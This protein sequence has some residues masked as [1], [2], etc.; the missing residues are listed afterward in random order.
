MTDSFQQVGVHVPEFPQPTPLAELLFSERDETR[1]LDSFTSTGSKIRARFF[2]GES[3]EASAVAAEYHCSIGNFSATVSILRK[4][5]YE[6]DSVRRDDGNY[7]RLTNA[8]HWPS[9]EQF[10]DNKSGA[11]RGTRSRGRPANNPALQAGLA[12]MET[13][14]DV[15]SVLCAVFAKKGIRVD[16]PEHLLLDL[17]LIDL[18]RSRMS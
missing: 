11:D 16:D 6:F 12:A 18:I 1:D 8:D 5:G 10:Q 3:M 13:D 14:R 9:V 17:N 7:Y 4:L 15:A 2:R